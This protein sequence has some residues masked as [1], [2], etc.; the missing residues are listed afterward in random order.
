[1]M[2]LTINK[3]KSVICFACANKPFCWCPIHLLLIKMKR[4]GAKTA[5]FFFLGGGGGGG[6]GRGVT[7]YG[8]CRM[9]KDFL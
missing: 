5:N 7:Q 8:A 3:H 4:K 1:M 2:T 6:G 9:Q